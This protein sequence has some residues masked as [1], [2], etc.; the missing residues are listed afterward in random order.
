MPAS[1]RTADGDI[2]THPQLAG[3]LGR[4]DKTAGSV[5]DGNRHWLAIVR[6]C[7][8]PSYLHFVR[9]DLTDS[10]ETVGLHK[11]GQAENQKA[12]EEF[13]TRQSHV[14]LPRAEPGVQPYSTAC[15]P[16][17]SIHSDDPTF[18][19]ALIL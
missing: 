19:P 16:P 2:A 1:E 18:A 4:I 13:K 5:S 10:L 3:F 9:S 17:A 6:G 12:D 15:Y 11:R 7:F 14:Y 8:L